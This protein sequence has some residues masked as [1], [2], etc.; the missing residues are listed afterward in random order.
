M[1]LRV[2]DWCLRRGY[3]WYGWCY[4]VR[5]REGWGSVVLLLRL[6][7]GVSWLYGGG[8]WGWVRVWLICMFNVVVLLFGIWFG[9]NGSLWRSGNSV[10][11]G[12]SWV[13]FGVMMFVCGCVELWLGVRMCGGMVWVFCYGLGFGVKFVKM[14]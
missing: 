12:V 1:C 14:L 9:V 4:G 7:C 6:R 11:G 3:G 10:V 13:C 2:I 8:S 5:S